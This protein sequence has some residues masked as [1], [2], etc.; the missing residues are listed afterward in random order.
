MKQNSVLLQLLGSGKHIDCHFLLL[1]VMIL[2][3]SILYVDRL[4]SNNTQILINYQFTSL[5]L[6]LKAYE[7]INVCNK[8][9]KHIISII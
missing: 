6:Q 7:L 2:T 9:Y 1:V 3:T 5:I 4:N 8:K